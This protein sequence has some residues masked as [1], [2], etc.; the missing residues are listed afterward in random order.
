MHIIAVSLLFAVGYTASLAG[1]LLHMKHLRASL[2]LNYSTVGD[3]MFCSVMAGILPIG[4]VLGLTA[5]I[6]GKVDWDAPAF[7]GDR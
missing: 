2:G 3:V 6:G 1:L 5:L 4:W 7:R